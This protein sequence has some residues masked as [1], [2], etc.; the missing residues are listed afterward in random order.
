LLGKEMVQSCLED[1]VADP[2][3]KALLDF[4]RK[5]NSRQVRQEDVVALRE[6]WSEE[7]AYT[8]ISVCALF[9]F[10]NRWVDG[11]GVKHLDAEGYAQSG[12]RLAARGYNF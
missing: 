6:H 10:Y 8:A 5:V 1:R 3:V 4:A 9:N 11:S 7:A 12:K 2:H